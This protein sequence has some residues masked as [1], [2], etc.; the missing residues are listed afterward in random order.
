MR[1]VIRVAGSV[2]P[3]VASAFDDLEVRTETVVSG[4]VVDDAA[5]HGVLQRLRDL[6][7]SVADLWVSSNDAPDAA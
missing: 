6:G 5:L 3:V 4:S 1:V 2:G 7:L